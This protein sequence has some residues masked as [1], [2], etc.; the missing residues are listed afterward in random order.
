MQHYTTWSKLS[1]FFFAAAVMLFAANGVFVLINA[2][3][4]SRRRQWRLLPYA[5]LSPL[6]WV[7]MSI[8]AWKGFLQLFW[9]PHHWEKTEHGL[10]VDPRTAVTSTAGG[11][12]KLTTLGTKQDGVN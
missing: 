1:W 10:T 7:L 8:G 4:C 3:A 2:V 9:R 5:L 11:Q 6:Y 12:V